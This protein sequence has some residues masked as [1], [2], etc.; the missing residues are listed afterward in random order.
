MSTE[1]LDDNSQSDSP[2]STGRELNRK[3]ISLFQCL[4]GMSEASSRAGNW[5]AKPFSISCAHSKPKTRPEDNPK[6]PKCL[7]FS[8]WLNNKPMCTTASSSFANN[9][10]KAG[11]LA[12]TVPH[13]TGLLAS[14][15]CSRVLPWL[16]KGTE[17]LAPKH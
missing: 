7:I 3:T 14:M 16:R 9:S 11:T 17:C 12:R 2:V 8:T 6:M 13:L 10:A 1:L 4:L 5:C 15:L